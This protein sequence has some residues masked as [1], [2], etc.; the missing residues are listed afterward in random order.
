MLRLAMVIAAGYFALPY[1]SGVIPESIKQGLKAD[2]VE[3]F[4]SVSGIFSDQSTAK[5]SDPEKWKNLFPD[6]FGNRASESVEQLTRGTSSLDEVSDTRAEWFPDLKF[7][8]KTQT[9]VVG[10]KCQGANSFTLSKE[11]CE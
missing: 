8:S 7:D 2:I 3:I 1:V 11:S 10:F 5:E 6:G 9:N 4:P